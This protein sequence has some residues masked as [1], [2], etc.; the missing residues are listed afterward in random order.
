MSRCAFFVSAPTVRFLR[1]L[2][3][4]SPL[5][6]AQRRRIAADVYTRIKPLVGGVDVDELRRAAAE[7]QAERWRLISRGVCHMADV[8]FASVV[9]TE[10]WLLAQAELAEAGAPVREALAGKR[11]EAI[12]DF[13]RDNL[14]FEAG[15][16]VHLH[17]LAS[18][19]LSA[20][21][22]GASKSVA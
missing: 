15:E 5:P 14:A 1:A 20:D 22:D 4:L 12:E 17:A 11:S 9:L 7:A 18:L 19:R 13:V 10:Q 6:S 3:E 2:Q 16:V 21:Q 8:G